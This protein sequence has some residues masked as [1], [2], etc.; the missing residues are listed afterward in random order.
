MNISFSRPSLVVLA[1]V[2]LVGLAYTLFETDT[3][4]SGPDSNNPAE[5][6]EASLELADELFQSLHQEFRNNT[7]DLKEQIGRLGPD[8]FSRQTI[9][10]HLSETD[11]WG[12]AIYRGQERLAWSG[13]DPTTQAIGQLPEDSLAVRIEQQENVTLMVAE[14][15]FRSGDNR[16]T[17]VTATRLSQNNVIPIARDQET[18]LS[19]HPRL[20]KHYPVEFSFFDPLPEHSYSYRSRPLALSPEDSA[21][22]VYA[23]Y[24]HSPEYQKKLETDQ[25]RLRTLFHISFFLLGSLLFFLISSSLRSWTGLSVQLLT[26]GATWYLFGTSEVPV[27]WIPLFFNSIDPDQIQAM[28]AVS[29]Y[30][31]HALFTFF[32]SFTVITTLTKKWRLSEPNSFFYT[33]FRAVLV[34]LVSLTLILFFLITTYQTGEKAGIALF[35]LELL[36][37]LDSW[38]LFIATGFFLCSITAL[39]IT[40]WWVLFIAERDK[41]TLVAL[42][43]GICF[44]VFYSLSDQFLEFSLLEGRVI[45]LSL[46][47]F[48]TSILSA[49][50]IYN[51][52]ESF[53]QL[54]GFRLLLLISLF[55]SVCGYLIYSMTEEKRLDQQ[56]LTAAEEFSFDEDLEAREITFQ[57]LSSIEEQMIFL[58][59]MDIE[60]RPAAVRA[61][62]QR[63]IRNSLA[64]SW[65]RYSFD[66][67]LLSPAGEQLGSYATSLDSPG[68]RFYDLFRMQTSYQQEQIRREN[69]RP[70]VQ[71]VSE[72]FSGYDYETLYRGWIPVYDEINPTRIIA[73]IAATIYLERPDFNKPIRAVLAAANEDEWKRSYYLASFRDGT[74]YRDS[75]QGI[76]SGQP[77][78]NRL[79]GR[80]REIAQS[81]SIAFISNQTRQGGFREVLLQQNDQSIIKAST[82]LPRF[83]HH[84]FSIFRFAFITLVAGTTLFLLLSLLGLSSFKLFGMNRSFR[85]RL[86]DGLAVGTLLLLLVLISAT[87]FVMS[88]QNERTLEKEIITKL[89]S[90]AETFQASEQDLRIGSGPLA[91]AVAPLNSDAILYRDGIVAESTTPQIFQQHLLPG[92]L[93]FTVYDYLYNRQRDHIIETIRIGDQ[94]L[95]IGYRILSGPEGEPVGVASIPTFLESPLYREQLLET[96][97]YLLVLYLLIIGGFISVTV[98]FA[99]Q[100]TRPLSSLREGLNKISGGD[101]ETTLPVRSQDEIGELSSAYNTMVR[102]L[103]ELQAEL[104]VAEREAAWREMARQ[105]AHE[106]KNPLTPIKLNL[107]HLKR[108]LDQSEETPESTRKLVNRVTESIIGQLESLNRIS[109]DFS[110]FAHPVHQPFATFDLNQMVRSVVRLYHTQDGHTVRQQLYPKPVPIHGSEDDLRRA[111]VNLIKNGLEASGKDGILTVRTDLQRSTAFLQVEDTG[112]G[113]PEELKKRIFTPNFST[114]SSGTGLGLAITRKIVEAHN[115]SISFESDPDHGSTFTIQLPTSYSLPK[116]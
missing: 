18:D 13:F 2:L 110:S 48:L 36:P 4:F 66:I 104:A 86:L 97:S 82:P 113:I 35:D 42:I 26:I 95:L 52:P 57:L 56:L 27:H 69:N 33:I 7:L 107:Q 83:N 60:V 51:R 25:S 38:I 22:V 15:T 10:Q 111:L 79:S 30:A 1:L 74:L 9:Y 91:R 16:F 62:F 103:R 98:L 68:S 58:T 105:I 49:I 28:Q 41:T 116:G 39:T 76:Y 20:A 12:S 94:P 109:S 54:S 50:F 29:Y 84:L 59:F 73:W 80:E 77:R 78:Y 88:H 19:S 44:L 81:D 37:E 47:L 114:K 64:E 92:L 108:Q 65:R 6:M 8:S 71:S 17:L 5:Q 70:V 24:D 21:G 61:Q 100:V 112:S 96:T 31:T 32:V 106:I 53:F 72:S 14:T 43:A 3:I 67:Q 85:S 11:F 99:N 87:Y 89:D 63:A 93:P 55:T 115:G 23:L 75:V 102:K 90:L 101:L 45:I 46:G 34:S 40:L